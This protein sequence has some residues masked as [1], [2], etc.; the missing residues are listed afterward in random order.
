ME[1][2]SLEPILSHKTLS[3]EPQGAPG[4]CP[5]AQGNSK[6]KSSSHASKLRTKLL[7]GGYIGDCGGDYDRGYEGG[8]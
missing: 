1:P 3:P 4:H 7:K 8:Y 6:K 5:P 2:H